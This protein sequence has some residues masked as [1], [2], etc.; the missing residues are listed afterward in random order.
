MGVS[1]PPVGEFTAEDSFYGGLYDL[2]EH[3][4]SAYD[5]S[6]SVAAYIRSTV[7]PVII[8]FR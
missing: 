3:D 1:N 7:G 6:H 2:F 5:N 8:E 4:C